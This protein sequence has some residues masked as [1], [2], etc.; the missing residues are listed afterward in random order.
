[1]NHSADTAHSAQSKSETERRRERAAASSSVTGQPDWV[2]SAKNAQ[3]AAD[4]MAAQ[5]WMEAVTGKR[6][7]DNDLWET[8]KS[9]VYLCELINRIKP[10]TVK[11]INKSARMPFHCMENITKYIEGCES[12][13]MRAGKLFRPP[14]LYEKRV[15]YPKAIINNIHGL[16]MI[17]EDTRGYRGPTLEVERVSGSKF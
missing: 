16:A 5:R 3:E 6:F 12:L 9:G 14:D 15:S 8:T 11:K 13:G 7:D 17:A 10:G 1:V 2:K 4:M